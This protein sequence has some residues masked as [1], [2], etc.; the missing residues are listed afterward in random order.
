MSVT[1]R[2]AAAHLAP[3]RAPRARAAGGAR[4]ARLRA[5]LKAGD[6]N[7]AQRFA[8]QLLG[9]RVVGAG[10]L[11]MT[12][13]RAGWRVVSV[14]EHDVESDHTAVL[15]TLRHRR[16][17][18]LLTVLVINCQGVTDPEPAAR[19][20]LAL[21]LELLPDLVLGTEARPF[22]A[23]DA[24]GAEAYAWHQ[25]GEKGSSES[26]TFVGGRLD[27]VELTELDVVMLSKATSEGGGIDTRSA[28]RARVTLR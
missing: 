3:P 27:T 8:A 15:I 17:G 28:A 5:K 2:A 26:G 6:L 9:R 18:R 19:R 12:V 14:S 1:L 11:W 4:L 21:G 20:S 10:V 13:P 23:A 25:P 22:R 24:R 16:S 7:L